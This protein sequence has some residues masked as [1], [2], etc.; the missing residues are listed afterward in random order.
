L[1]PQFRILFSGDDLTEEYGPLLPAI[2]DNAVGSFKPQAWNDVMEWFTAFPLEI[3]ASATSETQLAVAREITKNWDNYGKFNPQQIRQVLLQVVALFR[4]VQAA[5]ATADETRREIAVLVLSLP[6][7]AIIEYVTQCATDDRTTQAAEQVL[8]ALKRNEWSRPMAK[9]SV[10]ALATRS[11]QIRSTNLVLAIESFHLFRQLNSRVPDLPQSLKKED[12]HTLWEVY[13]PSRSV[14]RADMLA[15]AI[16][17][18][19]R[20]LNPGWLT[21]IAREIEALCI[22]RRFDEAHDLSR[23]KFELSIRRE[24]AEMYVNRLRERSTESRTRTM[25]NQL[26]PI[27]ELF[28]DGQ[29]RPR[30][31]LP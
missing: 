12:F 6:R 22:A 25:A 11:Q 30:F 5:A 15:A 29:Y 10:E 1:T 24:P 3:H 14:E 27:G 8:A 9:D 19:R 23:S 2:L 17:L 4:N 26:E 28:L 18:L 7:D 31:V 20:Y 16:A 21:P 13:D